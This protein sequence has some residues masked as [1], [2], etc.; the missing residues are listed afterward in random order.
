MTYKILVIEDDIALRKILFLRFSKVNIAA[1]SVHD[2]DHLSG[3]ISA[4]KPDCVLLD[5]MMLTYTGAKLF[6]VIRGRFLGPI[7]MYT[8]M[9]SREI[10]LMSLRLGA[11]DVIEKSRS[12]EV[13]HERILK[14][15]NEYKGLSTISRSE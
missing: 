14:A 10:E 6:S 5:S 8:G 2:I 4:V 13:L 9:L 11:T 3:L 12:F 15:I 1:F 7:I